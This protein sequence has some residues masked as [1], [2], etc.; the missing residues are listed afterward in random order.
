MRVIS[1]PGMNLAVIA[2]L[3]VAA[4]G[5]GCQN[6]PSA[7]ESHRADSSLHTDDPL[8]RWRKEWAAQLSLEI[9][10]PQLDQALLRLEEDAEDVGAHVRAYIALAG[11]G[12]DSEAKQHLRQ[13]AELASSSNDAK[14]LVYVAQVLWTSE[15]YERAFDLL[16]QASNLD[17]DYPD[18]R[19]CLVMVLRD[20]GNEA[21]AM[22]EAKSALKADPANDTIRLFYAKHL[23]ERGEPAQA[24]EVLLQAEPYWK[25]RNSQMW[26]E[27]DWY[28]KTAEQL[29]NTL[30][31]LRNIMPHVKSA[32]E[33]LGVEIAVQAEYSRL[34]ADANILQGEIGE[35]RH[36]LSWSQEMVHRPPDELRLADLLAAEGNIDEA[37]KHYLNVAPDIAQYVK[38]RLER[39][40][41]VGPEQ[42]TEEIREFVLGHTELYVSDAK[43]PEWPE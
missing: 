11:L 29:Q 43:V 30:L 27:V 6:R 31:A 19:R 26:R 16:K 10:Q 35:A 36:W 13:A 38:P 17:P 28:A 1:R 33:V 14:T 3:L 7:V 41:E 37:K 24:E 20:S 23:L 40:D 18:I 21:A 25:K 12:R 32:Q 4:M 2:C 5:G 9:L 42:F 15:D 39:F 8:S 34:L 22:Q